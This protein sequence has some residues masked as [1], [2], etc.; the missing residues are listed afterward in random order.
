MYDLHNAQDIVNH[1]W[2]VL[3]SYYDLCSDTTCTWIVDLRL[4]RIDIGIYILK[5]TSGGTVYIQM[6]NQ[7]K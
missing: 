4:I 6:C 5:L 3:H 7:H 1:T 2:K